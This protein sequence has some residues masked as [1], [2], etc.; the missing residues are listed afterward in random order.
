M[1]WTLEIA[2]GCEETMAAI[3]LVRL[4]PSKAFLPV[5]IS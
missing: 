3:R 5:A 1:A 2:G 4:L